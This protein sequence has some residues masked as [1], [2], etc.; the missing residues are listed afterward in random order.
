M[1]YHRREEMTG[2]A[3]A[4]EKIASCGLMPIVR[5]ERLDQALLAVEALYKGGVDVVEFP[6]TSALALKAMEKTAESWGDKMLMGAGTVLDAETARICIAAGAR[7]IVSP[8]VNTHVITL[9]KRHSIAVCPG[10]LTPTEV[11]TAWEAGADFVKI[12]P[13]GNVGGPNYIKQLKAPYPHIRMMPVGG[14][15]FQNAADFIKAGSD[16]LGTGNTCIDPK[17]VASGDFDSITK[18][19]SRFMEIIIAARRAA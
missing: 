14:V 19:A 5:F 4:A 11:L 16:A 13:C 2:Q 15:T 3:S 1:D 6:M 18:N 17:S 12:F 9:C 8:A 10:A 7:F